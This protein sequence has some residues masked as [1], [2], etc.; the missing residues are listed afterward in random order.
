MIYTAIQ[1]SFTEM[2]WSG[3]FL[4]VTLA[5]FGEVFAGLYL[6]K[7][8]HVSVPSFGLWIMN[9]AQ[10]IRCNWFL[11]VARLAID[12]SQWETYRHVSVKRGPLAREVIHFKPRFKQIYLDFWHFAAA[13]SFLHVPTFAL[14]RSR[15]VL[16]LHL[17]FG[18]LNYDVVRVQRIGWWCNWFKS[19]GKTC[20]QVSV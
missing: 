10:C 11:L 1:Y 5:I 16:L 19:V 20:S 15:S 4:L 8:L 12:S 7:F 17:A 3:A 2:V 6:V 9:A 13:Q 18:I 14:M